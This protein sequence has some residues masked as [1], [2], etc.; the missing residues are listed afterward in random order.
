MSA[1]KS[2]KRGKLFSVKFTLKVF[3]VNEFLS[4]EYIRQHVGHMTVAVGDMNDRRSEHSS[5]RFSHFDFWE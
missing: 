4:V 1:T 5:T 2:S 3:G